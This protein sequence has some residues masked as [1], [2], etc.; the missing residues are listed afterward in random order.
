[1]LFVFFSEKNIPLKN[2][3]TYSC[4]T[5]VILGIRTVETI[6]TLKYLSCN[7]KAYNQTL[8][9]ILHWQNMNI[10]ITKR[11][12][13]NPETIK[14]VGIFFIIYSFNVIF[15]ISNNNSTTFYRVLTTI[16]YTGQK[17]SELYIIILMNQLQQ[18]ILINSSL[19][20]PS[21]Y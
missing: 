17:L 16:I 4:I 20:F 3:V 11:T 2:S 18:M 9:R 5:L 19:G 6:S 21:K 15:M 7:L 12:F 14:I 13:L 1:M 10:F 8:Q